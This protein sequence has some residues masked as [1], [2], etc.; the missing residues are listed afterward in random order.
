EI[1]IQNNYFMG[2]RRALRLNGLTQGI[3]RN[4][5]FWC[6]SRH[7]PLTWEMVEIENTNMDSITWE[8]NTFINNGQ[9]GW[10]KPWVK[11]GSKTDKVINGKNGKPT[12]T[13][14]FK[15]V[16]KYEPD[17]IHLIVYNWDHLDR[18]TVDLDTLLAPG[19]TYRVVNVVDFFGDPV[20]EG[21]AENSTI[22]LPMGRHRYEPEFGT[23]I[24]FKNRD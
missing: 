14:I 2:G 10:M 11:T 23:Y 16:N 22:T 15:R 3:V 24:L 13:Q 9:F 7:P 4:N 19:D 12:G 21:I 20:V 5:T 6:P 18:V 1:T 17:R 8:N